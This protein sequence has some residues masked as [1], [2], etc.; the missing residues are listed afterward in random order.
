IDPHYLEWKAKELNF[1][2]HFISL[3][4]EINRKMP[5]FV[6]EK[7]TRLLNRLG[8]AVSRSRILVMGVAYK[9][10][11]GDFRESPSLDVIR[12]LQAQ[13]AEVLYHD[14]YV[15]EFEEHGLVMHSSPLTE[16]VVADSDLVLITTDHGRIDYEWLVEH[17]RHVLDT[18]NTTQSITN[19]RERITLL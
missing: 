15:P 18:R 11:L 16:E 9:K 4:G 10:N 8:K 1:N 7:A 13:G 17:A 3:A 14:P 12:L 5:Q 6:A 2:T 19:N